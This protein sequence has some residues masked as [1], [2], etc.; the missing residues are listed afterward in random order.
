MVNLKLLLVNLVELQKMIIQFLLSKFFFI[1]SHPQN[2]GK[3]LLEVL[4]P[5]EFC[6][7]ISRGMQSFLFYI[8][9]VIDAWH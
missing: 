3:N 9:M 1:S 4:E 2:R 5:A 6:D 7:K 8:L